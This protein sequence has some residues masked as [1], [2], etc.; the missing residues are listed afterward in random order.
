VKHKATA[1]ALLVIG[2]AAAYGWQ[3]VP[4]QYVGAAWYISQSLWQVVLLALL[5]C[6]YRSRAVVLVCALLAVFSLMVAGCEAAF[7]VKPWP[8]NPGDEL[9][10]ARLNYPLG[11]LG[12][13]IALGLVLSI[14][15]EQK[16]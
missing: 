14:I 4:A 15:R 12:A 6:V 10:S 16:R 11:L 1:L 9:C 2:C 13:V 5:A 8:M 7:L 3:F